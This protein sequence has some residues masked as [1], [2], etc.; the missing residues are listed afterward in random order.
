MTK[1]TD[2]PYVAEYL[3]RFDEAAASLATTRRLMLR[4]EIAEHLRDVIDAS[5]SEGEAAAAIAQFG[6]PAEVLAQELDN[7]PS[8]V[9]PRVRSRWTW[10]T[11]GAAIILVFLVASIPIL[12]SIRGETAP[13]PAT[14][15]LSGN[16]VTE[17]PE[18][19]E[20]VTT[21]PAY[22]E[23]LAAIERMD[24]PLPDGVNY[25]LGVPEGLDAGPTSDGEG[26]M[27]SGAGTVIAHFSWLCAWESEYLLAVD[28]ADDRRQVDAE[29]MISSW[30]ESEFYAAMGDTERSWVKNVV[31]PMQFNNPTGVKADRT[32]TC[33]QAGIFNVGSR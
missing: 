21:G 13:E 32:Q 29:A 1:P 5:A 16:P 26:T 4:E 3:L 10:W 30:A 2:H 27:Q 6:S 22:F 28:A 23:Y 11:I 14:P 31:D 17:K 25:P 33:A 9:A 19:P 7:D 12:G 18:G 8:P 20:R 24:H 15:P